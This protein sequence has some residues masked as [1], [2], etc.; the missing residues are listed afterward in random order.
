MTDQDHIK[1]AQI[2]NKEWNNLKNHNT[3]A[4]FWDGISVMLY[5]K[6]GKRI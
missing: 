4:S 5:N 2:V 3:R 1:L 6:T